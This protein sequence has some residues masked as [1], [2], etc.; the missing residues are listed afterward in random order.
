MKKWQTG[1]LFRFLSSLKLAV[2]II[3]SLSAI[4]AVATVLEAQYGMRGAH[5]MVYGQPWFH[6]VLIL[7]GVNVLCAA[8]SRW[9]WK[10]N[11]YG[12]AI[13][14]AGILILLFGS[15][16]TM[17]Y[18]VDGNLPVV[19]GSSDSEVILHDLEFF[20][21]DVEAQKVQAYPIPESALK[22]EGKL[23]EVQLPSD[24]K[25]EVRTFLPR[26]RIQRVVEKSPVTIGL[27]AVH[28]E[29]FNDRFSVDEWI[30]S[31][32]P[33][34][35]TEINLGPA[36]IGLQKLW[37]DPQEKRFLAGQM[38]TP[39]E[40]AG[41]KG[42]VV[43]RHEGK[44]YRIDIDEGLR[45]WRAIGT[46]G[47][48]LHIERYLPYAIVQKNELV[49]KGD[50]PINPTVQILLQNKDGAEEKHT[51]FANFPDFATLHRKSKKANEVEFP[52]QLRMIAAG[53]AAGKPPVRGRLFFA[54]TSDDKRLLYRIT[55]S[56]SRLLGE[57]DVEVG[58]AVPTGWMD[59]KFKV[60]EWYPAAVQ[61]DVPR[62]VEKLQGS[63]NFPAAIQ[64][65]MLKRDVASAADNR[66]LIEGASTGVSVGDQILEAGFRR[67]RI[68]L[69][70]KIHLEKFNMGVDPGTTKAASYESS[71]SVVDPGA[72]DAPKGIISMNEPLEYG[73][74]T[75]YQASYQM[76][77]GQPP[78]SVFSVNFDPGRWVKYAGSLTMV[79]G[80]LLMFYLNPHYWDILLGR[81][82]K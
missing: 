8:L 54:Q 42:Y 41:R 68:S 31:D 14:H 24:Q 30:L 21:A 23:L 1:S 39:A 63:E 5:L 76:R 11:Q 73:G 60:L 2:P 74:Y 43:V 67:D 58:K 13:T 44:E 18:G 15:W 25:V 34:G 49:N 72:K 51:L 22:R 64:I 78:I 65:Q 3:L 40:D 32:R 79:F 53:P 29:V 81:K 4:L 7:L 56:E 55:G 66:W 71:V 59:L 16:L 45:G 9:P 50:K 52:V 17:Q 75:F 69:P 46:G 26:A 28:V 35:S 33:D 70:F 80:I 61:K 37:S 82:H 12:F 47:I 57:G 36:M 62:Y 27:P 20:L 48:R 19:E 38:A 6:G 10:R 77:D